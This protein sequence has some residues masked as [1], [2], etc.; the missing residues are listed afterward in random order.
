MLLLKKKYEGKGNASFSPLSNKSSFNC[1]EALQLP[2]DMLFLCQQIL[3]LFWVFFLFV[4]CSLV[5]VLPVSEHN[6]AKN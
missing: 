2:N 5:L 4:F 6:T 1:K 3:L